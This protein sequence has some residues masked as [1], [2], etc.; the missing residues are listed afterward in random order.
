MYVPYIYP[1]E[2]G[3]RMNVREVSFKDNSGN[4]LLIEGIPEISFTAKHYTDHELERAKHTYD[5]KENGLININ[6][7]HKQN[8]LG[9]SSC[10]PRLAEKYICKPKDFKYGFLM[11]PVKK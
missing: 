2:F 11:K 6:I 3:N 8:G 4:G 7:D 9:S 5:L 1:Q 10:G